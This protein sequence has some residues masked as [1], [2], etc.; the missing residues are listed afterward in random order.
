MISTVK[1]LV[2][3]DIIYHAKA[4]FWDFDGVIKDSV[5]MKSD[6]FEKLFTPF[7]KEVAENVR[8][9]HEA[10]GGVSRYEKLPLYLEWAGEK[11]LQSL[12]HEYSERFSNLVKQ[13][14]IESEWVPGVLS[15]LQHN[16]NKQTFFLVTGTPQDEIEEILVALNIEQIFTKVIG[17]PTKKSDAIKQILDKH[18][19]KLDQTVMIGDSQSDYVAAIENDIPFVLRRTRLN[20]DLQEE[21][22]YPMINDFNDE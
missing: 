22:N 12:I 15:Y 19:I 8:K 17:A 16:N 14:V 7:G 18:P 5:E 3:T 10:N 11:P 2:A 20:Q 13:N 9:H 21:L 6:A 4:I 1:N